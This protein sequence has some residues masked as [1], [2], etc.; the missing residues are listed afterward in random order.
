MRLK[1]GEYGAKH[2]I[3]QHRALG[4]LGLG[5]SGGL[6]I[7]PPDTTPITPQPAA[8]PKVHLTYHPS[9]C[10]PAWDNS[11]NSTRLFCEKMV[12]ELWAWPQYT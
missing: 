5:P 7:Y 3:C 8:Q 2:K 4:M 1:K 11:Y 6:A 9:A 12:W 10:H